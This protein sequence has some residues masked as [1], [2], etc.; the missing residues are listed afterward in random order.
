V[1]RAAIVYQPRSIALVNAPT[2]ALAQR[3]STPEAR[4]RCLEWVVDGMASDGPLSGTQTYEELVVEFISRG[5]D[6][7]SAEEAA[8]ALSGGPTSSNGGKSNTG[9]TDPTAQEAAVEL[10]FA[11]DQG[12]IAVESCPGDGAYADRCRA[13]WTALGLEAIELLP[14][15][16]VLTGTFGFTRGAPAPG[17]TPL[18]WFHGPG[19]GVRVHGHLGVGEALL[20]RL[21]PMMVS[22]WLRTRGHDVP[23]TADGSAARRVLIE[24]GF[25]PLQTRPEPETA[26]HAVL[27]LIHSLAHRIIRRISALAGIDRDSLAEYL[28][29][30][31]LCFAIYASPRGDFVLGGLQ[32]LFEHDL[33][34]ALYEVLHGEHRC[35]LDPGCRREGGACVACL[36]LG[37]PSCRLFNQ[38]L[39][40][41]LMYAPAG[42]LAHVHAITASADTR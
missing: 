33:D 14:Q 17:Q 19:G 30:P 23:H 2:S 4:V 31:H 37:E 16:P 15:F 6:R 22:E 40:R 7:E 1:H 34:L 5:F 26:S 13:A 38:Y 9:L 10:A 28:L 42:Y 20:F 27:G 12:R 11:T 41:G 24:G 3:V 32:A 39:D 36:H 25:V 8:L 21:H 29:P 18:R 35:P